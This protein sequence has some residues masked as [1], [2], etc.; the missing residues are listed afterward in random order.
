MGICKVSDPRLTS[1]KLSIVRYLVTSAYGSFPGKSHSD[2]Q[3]SGTSHFSCSHVTTPGQSEP[4]K[5][6]T[7]QDHSTE[8]NLSEY[9]NRTQTVSLSSVL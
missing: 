5:H 2:D 1:D 8:S 7:D 9:T 3:T 4:V 6:A